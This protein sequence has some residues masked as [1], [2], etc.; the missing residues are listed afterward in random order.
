MCYHPVAIRVS[1]NNYGNRMKRFLQNKFIDME[2]A[3]LFHQDI[4]DNYK[5]IYV[6]CGKCY[7]CRMQRVNGWIL[8]ASHE[9]IN[10]NNKAVMITLTYNNANLGINSLDYKDFQDFLKRLRKNLNGREIKYIAVG[11]YGYE[12]DRKHF[13]AFLF[14][15]TKYDTDII[16]KSWQKGFTYVKNADVNALRYILKYSFKQ[17]FKNNEHYINEGKT[18]PM[19]HCSKSLGKNIALDKAS[20]YLSRGYFIVNGFKYNIPRYYFKV[21]K[22]HGIIH[23]TY[24]FDNADYNKMFY[25]YLCKFMHKENA[26]EL[27]LKFNI[28]TTPV[29]MLKGY[30]SLGYDYYEIYN[31]SKY[32]FFIENLKEVA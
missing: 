15:V 14:N 30:L 20:E 28:D 8:R 12:S 4:N 5:T 32:R 22:N 25:E 9:L 21:L 24:N 13:H 3:H 23:D 29:L 10:Y 18:A 27:S 31:E 16:N 19:F 17:Q 11:E 26:L 7:K 1:I 6:S 2:M